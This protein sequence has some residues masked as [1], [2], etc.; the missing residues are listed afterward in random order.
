MKRALL[1][2][3]SV[4]LC[5]A[6]LEYWAQMRFSL[7]NPTFPFGLRKNM[8]VNLYDAHCLTRNFLGVS[9]SGIVYATD[10]YGFLVNPRGSLKKEKMILIGGD[11]RAFSLFLNWNDSLAGQ[12]EGAQVGH[13]MEAFPGNS[14]ALFN[15]HLF[16]NH[17][18]EEINPKPH[19]IY[20]LY[21]RNDTFSDQQFVKE[22]ANPLPWY[23]SRSIKL[24]LGGYFWNM[25]SI[26]VRSFLKKENL[27]QKKTDLVE[28]ENNLSLEKQNHQAVIHKRNLSFRVY[29]DSL[30]DM[31]KYCHAVRIPMTILYIPRLTELLAA[32][33]YVRDDLKNW[34][35]QS[36]VPMIDL[37]E[38]MQAICG[39]NVD[40][41]RPYFIDLQEGIHFSKAGLAL[42]K[43]AI[44][45]FEGQ[46]P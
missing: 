24:M 44:L 7:S 1:I 37:Y 18:I 19:R 8:G 30:T 25:V 34:C 10:K 2:F 12:L 31:K 35:D 4:V 11:S 20:Y 3:L 39:G 13:F 6:T 36:S 26:K 15:H 22:L 38:P 14:P 16:S 42:V 27:I 46:Y 45:E 23:S 43:D 28:K 33:S 32:N 5:Y 29:R 17:L 40:N 41:L 9:G 21:D